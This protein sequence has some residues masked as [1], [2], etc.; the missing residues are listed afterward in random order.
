LSRSAENSSAIAHALGLVATRTKV[1]SGF[2]R[3]F[4]VTGPTAAM[5]SAVKRFHELE[6][7]AIEERSTKAPNWH[8]L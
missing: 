6:A 5:R 3:G 1:Q 7:P 4:G 8:A 2:A